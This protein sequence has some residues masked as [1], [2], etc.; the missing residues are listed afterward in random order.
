MGWKIGPLGERDKAARLTGFLKGLPLP[1][2]IQD[3]RELGRKEGATGVPSGG[4]GVG[5]AE[6]EPSY[7]SRFTNVWK[8]HELSAVQGPPS[9]RGPSTLG[10]GGV[11]IPPR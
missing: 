9:Q 4:L 1:A 2:L 5:V 3:I 11:S 10:W 6:G 8:S 7:S